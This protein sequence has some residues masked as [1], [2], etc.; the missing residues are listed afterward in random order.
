MISS[1]TG[2]T[3]LILALASFQAKS[4]GS[5]SVFGQRADNSALTRISKNYRFLICSSKSSL[6]S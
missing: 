6:G 3:M 1:P 5:S 4:G 2:A